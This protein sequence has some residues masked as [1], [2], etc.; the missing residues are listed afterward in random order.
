MRKVLLSTA[1]AAVLALP[2]AS[3][4]WAHTTGVNATTDE[5]AVSLQIGS[6]E[7]QASDGLRVV[8]G[9]EGVVAN[10]SQD[11]DEDDGLLEG[12]LGGFNDNDSNDGDGLLD[13]FDYDEDDGEDSDG[14]LGIFDY[15][16]EVDEDRDGLLGGIL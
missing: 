8:L 5:D 12:I 3:P 6:Q 4:A 1:L 7:Q 16:E 13:I 11:H 10:L 15:D 14:L 2:Q 9:D